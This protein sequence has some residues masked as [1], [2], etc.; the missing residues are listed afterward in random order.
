MHYRRYHVHGDP[1][2][3]L[4]DLHS[5]VEVYLMMRVVV[6]FESGCW[7]W[8]LAP[9]SEGYGESSYRGNR[10]KAHVL[11]YETFIGSVPDG[12]F[13]L[14]HCDNRPCV[15]PDHLYAGTKKDNAQDRVRRGR[16]GKPGQRISGARKR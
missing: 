9:N 11:S 15:M 10:K 8:S 4:I 13:V 6:G 1:N 7:E 5:S 16:Q 14:H 2:F 3:V 12:L